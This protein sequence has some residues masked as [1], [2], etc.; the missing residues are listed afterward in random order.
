[1]NASMDSVTSHRESSSSVSNE[2]CTTF[3][4]IHVFLD[5]ACTTTSNRTDK[6][7][8]SLSTHYVDI[9]NLNFDK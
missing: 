3:L 2:F 9:N 5:Y 4:N 1:M 8:A 6:G 7:I